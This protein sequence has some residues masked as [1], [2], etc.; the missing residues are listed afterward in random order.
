MANE[1]TKLTITLTGRAP[2]MIDKEKWPEIASSKDW[3]NQHECQANRTWKLTVRQ[4]ED[5]RAIVYG[6][7][8]SQFQG[9]AV[10]RGGE[11]LDTNRP[12]TGTE[13]D[14]PG[15]ITR[16]AEYLG[17]DQGLADRCIADLPAVEI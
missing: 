15:A 5:G 4:H 11:L 13:P 7:Y 16:V 2:V 10:K 3:D 17:F 6:V 12:G 1:N 8:R 9:E 14:I